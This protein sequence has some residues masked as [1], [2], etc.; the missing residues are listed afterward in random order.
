MKKTVPDKTKGGGL[1]VTSRHGKITPPPVHHIF[2]I[3]QS[4]KIHIAKVKEVKK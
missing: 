2:E 1:F 4:Q 3:S